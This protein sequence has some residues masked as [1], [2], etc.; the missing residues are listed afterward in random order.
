M[1]Y[2]RDKLIS[3]LL[4]QFIPCILHLETRISIK[5]FTILL[6]DGLS[7]HLSGN[8]PITSEISSENERIARFVSLIK[9]IINTTILGDLYSLSQFH[10]LIEIN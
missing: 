4:L 6:E 3:Y 1:H 7:D 2:T 8:H 5:L 10:I 9:A